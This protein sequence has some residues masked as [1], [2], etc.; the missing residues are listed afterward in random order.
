MVLSNDTGHTRINSMQQQQCHSQTTNIISHHRRAPLLSV[1]SLFVSNIRVTEEIV[2]MNKV[3]RN[4]CIFEEGCYFFFFWY[5]ARIVPI[6]LPFLVASDTLSWS[7]LMMLKSTESASFRQKRQSRTCTVSSRS[8][9]MQ[10]KHPSVITRARNGVATPLSRQGQNKPNRPDTKNVCCVATVSRL[11]SK[12]TQQYVFC[13]LTRS[14]SKHWTRPE[15]FIR[16]RK[17]GITLLGLTRTSQTTQIDRIM[18]C[19]A[20]FNR[21]QSTETT[22]MRLS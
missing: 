4:G 9:T 12:K 8:K 10:W 18:C 15:G 3:W 20:T 13:G 17:G 22:Q 21:L 11:L 14:R 2:N 5:F 7:S 1:W 19:A 6:V 16:A